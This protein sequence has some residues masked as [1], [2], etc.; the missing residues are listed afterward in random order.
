MTPESA[1]LT[2]KGASAA[3]L[4][5]AIY[6][7]LRRLA[8][9]LTTHLPPGQTHA[10]HHPV[11]RADVIG[12]TIFSFLCAPKASRQVE[13]VS[14]LAS[15]A[16][17]GRRQTLHRSGI[18]SQKAVSGKRPRSGLSF[19]LLA[20]QQVLISRIFLDGLKTA[21]FYAGLLCIRNNLL[22]RC[23]SRSAI[24]CPYVPHPAQE[25]SWRIWR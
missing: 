7:E 4:L 6:A 24:F 15:M 3:A 20:P 2:L 5:L 1:D 16:N 14:T 9:A 21:L 11:P 13:S 17:G 19:Y 10:N 22:D 23:L 18:K 25:N 12:T 8:A